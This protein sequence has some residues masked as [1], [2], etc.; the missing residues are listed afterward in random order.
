EMNP[1]PLP[2][3]PSA[4]LSPTPAL[5][6]WWLASLLCV[7][8]G[9]LTKWTAPAFFYGTVLPLLWW[10][11]QLRLLWGRRHIVSAALGAG[12]CLA[13]IGAVV[14]QI[15]WEELYDTVSREALQRLSPSHHRE[16][17]QAMASHHEPRLYPWAE[18]L[19]HPFRILAA[20]LPW[21]GLA[22]VTMRRRFVQLWD[23]RGRRLLVALH[24]CPSPYLI[25]CI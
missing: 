20:S 14:A 7:A 12:V 23:Q 3:S 9:V 25:S 13:R 11:G 2:P 1:V 6:R 15:G 21:S 10:R 19:A 5:W 24:C 4:S 17:Q 18:V 8:G 22:L 16:A